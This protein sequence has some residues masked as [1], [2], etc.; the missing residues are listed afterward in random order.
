VIVLHQP[1]AVRQRKRQLGPPRRDR[2]VVLRH[3]PLREQGLVRTACLRFD[4]EHDDAGGLAVEPVQRRQR[5]D[6][7]PALQ[8]HEQRFLQVPATGRDRQEVRLVGDDQPLVLEQHD[9]VERQARFVGDRTVVVQPQ[10][11]SVRPIRRDGDA[12]LVD[13][14]AL[15]HAGLP[16]R[17]RHRRE[18][19]DQEIADRRPRPGRQR[20]AARADTVLGRQRHGRCCAP[21]R[22]AWRRRGGVH[23][24]G[25]AVPLRLSG[26][27]S[28]STDPASCCA[29]RS[30][31]AS[32][33]SPA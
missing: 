31:H 21:T 6:A 27:A 4:R 30:R 10:A 26:A 14:F 24:D 12:V 22:C 32:S 8:P 23:G 20:D 29:R 5:V 19:L 25:F 16:G 15:L 7:E 17:G 33:G 13:Q 18:A 1:A 11:R 28:T 9:L 2:F 3:L